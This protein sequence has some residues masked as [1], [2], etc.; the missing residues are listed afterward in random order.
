MA[1]IAA[2]LFGRSTTPRSRHVRTGSTLSDIQTRALM[3]RTLPTYSTPPSMLG[4]DMVLAPGEQRSFT[5]SLK[6]PADLPPSFHGHSVHF[7]YYLTVGTSRLD[8][9]TGTQPSRLLH[10][11]IRVYNH[12]APGVGALARFDL[13]NPIVTCL[14]YTSPSPR[15][16]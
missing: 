8:A 5:F 1:T 10:V 12:V 6:L 3:S 2:L 4:I 9:R 13:L 11:P 15:D 16:S 7:D 14:L